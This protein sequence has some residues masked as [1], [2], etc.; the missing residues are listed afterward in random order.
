M[1]DDNDNIQKYVN[2]VLAMT[3][4]LPAGSYIA[5]DRRPSATFDGAASVSRVNGF[6]ANLNPQKFS[7]ESTKP[8]H[9][10]D[11]LNSIFVSA[12]ISRAPKSITIGKMAETIGL[13]EI[14]S[15]HRTFRFFEKPSDLTVV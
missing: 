10:I 6:M 14:K 9:G 13:Q 5:F 15:T 8:T 11:P 2:L 4:I 1:S 12:L 7:R 3:A